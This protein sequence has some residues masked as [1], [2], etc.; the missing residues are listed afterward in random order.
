MTLMMLLTVLI[1]GFIYYPSIEASIVL[2]R[3]KTLKEFEGL[4]E[5]SKESIV[6]NKFLLVTLILIRLPLLI[7]VVPILIIHIYKLAKES[8]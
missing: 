3:T 7:V 1:I 8:K 6:S 4:L 2:L 5:S